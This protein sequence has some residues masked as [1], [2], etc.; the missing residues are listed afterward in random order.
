[1]NLKKALTPKDT[2]ELK[3]NFYVQKRKGEYKQILPFV[4]NDKWLVREQLRTV[5]SI[6]TVVTIA[7]I[8]F[9]VWS[10]LHDTGLYREFYEEVMDDP[11]K[12][13]EQVNS[14]EDGDGSS[15][16]LPVGDRADKSSLQ[17]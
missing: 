10:Y 3:S 4:W 1:M 8:L 11:Y 16:V 14:M 15:F 9:L 12:F 6:R 5:I 2:E 7:I 13:C 17:P